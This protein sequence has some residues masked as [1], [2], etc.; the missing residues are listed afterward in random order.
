M[1]AYNV[2]R[3][4]GIFECS[5]CEQLRTYKRKIVRRCVECGH[6]D[7]IQH[8]IRYK[9]RSRPIGYTRTFPPEDIK[10]A[11]AAMKRAERDGVRFERQ[12]TFA[13]LKVTVLSFPNAKSKLDSSFFDSV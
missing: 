7:K 13:G 8:Q 9:W 3:G 10:S 1:I 4:V 5:K 12:R 6:V 11:T 2:K